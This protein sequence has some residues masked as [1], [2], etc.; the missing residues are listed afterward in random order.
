MRLGIIGQGTVGRAIARTYLEFVD[1]VRIWDIRPERKTYALE[2]T[3]DT[4][5]CFICLPTPANTDGR[6][7][8]SVIDDFCNMLGGSHPDGNYVLKSTVPIGTTREL[9]KKYGLANLVH[10]PEFLTARCA[11]TDS[12][13]PACNI[14]GL[15]KIEK[16]SPCGEMLLELYEKRFPGIN[17][18][19]MSFEESEAVKLFTNGFYAV[20][21]AYFNEIR[22]LADK[23]NL[24]WD[25]IIRGMLSQGRIAPYHYKVPGPDGKTGFGGEC[26]KKDLSQLV[27]HL[28]DNFPRD[29]S[30]D[31]ILQHL[32]TGAARARN[33]E[34]DRRE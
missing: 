20:K 8:I 33:Q 11:E 30:E 28:I 27:E 29:W 31:I 15:E 22:T 32:I 6:L 24:D 17:V 18:E 3:L 10:S 26:L 5:I 19:V 14:I 2:G 13:I 16:P 21:V 9:Q 34:I 23:L 12:M 25:A 7:D 4:N 1:E